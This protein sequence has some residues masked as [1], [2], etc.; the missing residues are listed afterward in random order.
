MISSQPVETEEQARLLPAVR[1]V[2]AAFDADP[3]TGKMAPHS[4]RLLCEALTA[5]GVELGGYDHRIAE[6]LS[7]WEP[8]TVAVIAGWVQRASQASSMNVPA[9]RAG[10]APK[11]NTMTTCDPSRRPAVADQKAVLAAFR[12][13]LTR[14]ST[15]P[16][17]DVH[18]DV[19][20]ALAADAACPAC[21]AMAAAELALA[22]AA[23]I[24]G[25]VYVSSELAA[26][27]LA[28]VDAAEAD[29]DAM[30]T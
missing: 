9:S 25:E 24:S 30:R 22:L 5:A 4:H 21:T 18:N 17:G 16:G 15:G 26:R 13:F 11:E 3:G 10:Q 8:Q 12:E 14:G 23:A 19:H 28:L 29:L 1:A 20:D 7:T 2:Y 27:L 6:W